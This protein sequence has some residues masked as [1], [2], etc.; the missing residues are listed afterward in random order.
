MDIESC[1]RDPTFLQGFVQCHR[2]NNGSP[3]RIDQNAIPLHQPQT[4]LFDHAAGGIIERG[5]D[6]HDV[7]TL[8]ELLFAH[9]PDPISFEE[10]PVFDDVI[11]N[12][13]HVKSLHPFNHDLPNSADSDNSQNLSMHIE[14]PLPFPTTASDLTI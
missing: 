10:F 12:D 1:T 3:R 6:R 4:L 11:G 7:R 2:V 5:V 8:Q 13:V 14:R 9:R